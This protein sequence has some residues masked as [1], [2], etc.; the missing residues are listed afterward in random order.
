MAS[1][2][3]RTSD[4]ARSGAQ[5]GLGALM[6]D[7]RIREAQCNDADI[8]QSNAWC[9][10]PHS[11]P[12]MC[13]GLHAHPCMCPHRCHI[14]GAVALY[15]LEES[16]RMGVLMF[17]GAGRRLRAAPTIRS[18]SSQQ[19]RLAVFVVP[20]WALPAEELLGPCYV[21]QQRS[22]IAPL[23]Q[24]RRKSTMLF[25]RPEFALRNK[26][27]AHETQRPA[28]RWAELLGPLC[29]WCG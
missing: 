12:T 27:S 11:M 22:S 15:I 8:V 16:D 29:R 4:A 2:P 18:A 6:H 14:C 17:F 26:P 28:L 20:L 23:L 24:S 5:S 21:A 13:I 7:T 19:V 25:L 10:P 3:P 1:N 9:L